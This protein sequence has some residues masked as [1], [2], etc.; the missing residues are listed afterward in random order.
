MG[1]TSGLEVDEK[2]IRRCRDIAT[3]IYLD[4]DDDLNRLFPKGRPIPD[5]I[6][7]QTSIVPEH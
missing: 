7:V 2:T 5:C 4:D 1:R 3:A 6:Y